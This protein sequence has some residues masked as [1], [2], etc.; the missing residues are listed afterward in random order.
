[1]KID[2]YFSVG[3]TSDV[4]LRQNIPEALAAEGIQAEVNYHRIS[5]EEAEE[6]GLRGS[7][8]ILIDGMDPFPS[9]IDGFS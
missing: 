2:C 1:M 4:I 9:E 8:T 6:L 7:P 5:D 3:C